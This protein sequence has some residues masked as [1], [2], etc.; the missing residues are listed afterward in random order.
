MAAEC[1]GWVQKKPTA[2]ASKAWNE[3]RPQRRFI[4]SR[5]FVIQ[6]FA[7]E[8]QPGKPRG[9]PRGTFDLRD[10]TMIRES[11]DPTAPPTAV[12][13]TARKH[14]FTLS[15]QSLAERDAF[16]RIW[17]SGVS[18][19]AVPHVLLERYFDAPPPNQH[20]SIRR[21]RRKLFL[22]FSFWSASS[23]TT[24]VNMRE[25]CKAPGS[26]RSSRQSWSW[27]TCASCCP[28]HPSHIAC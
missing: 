6:Y 5:A 2:A 23:R 15:F 22:S 14:R 7:E 10:V 4:E 8:P 12:D 19:S 9:K 1:A 27:P 25:C 28:L 26:T 18:T 3:C 11:Q 20:L 21:M 16:L 24:P 17:V 13:L